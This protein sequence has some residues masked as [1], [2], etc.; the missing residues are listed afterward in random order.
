[1]TS[2]NKF[3]TLLFLIIS[4]SFLAA[5]DQIGIHQFEWEQYK[6]VE[7]APSKFDQEGKDIIPLNI[8]KAENLSAAVFGYLPDW[9]YNN[10]AHQYIRYDLLSHIACFDFFVS[11]NG[12][13]SN[14]GGW[15]WTDVINEAHTNGTKVIL[16]AVNFDPDD[17]RAIITNP[18]AKQ[19][20]FNNVKEKINTYSL[21]GVNIDFESLYN[22]DK[23]SLIV[24]F[25]TDLT[26]FIHSELPGK[27]VSFAGPAVNWGDH[28][29]I[30]GLAAS[31]DYIFIMGYAFAGSWSTITGANSPLTGGNIN[32]TNTLNDQYQQVTLNYPE[33]LILGIPYYGHHWV[34]AGS[35]AGSSI[36][37]FVSSTRFT[38][39]KPHAQ[40]Y[41]FNWSSQSQSTWYKWNDGQWHQIWYDDD[42][43]LG[44]KYDLA[45]SKNLKGVGMWALGYDK[46]RDELWNLLDWK[47]GSGVLPPPEKPFHF[48]VLTENDSTLLLKYNIPFRATGVRIFKSVN[49][50]TFTDSVDVSV[51]QISLSGLTT[52]SVYYFRIKSFNSSGESQLS[53]VL[54]GVPS[55]TQKHV[56]IV[57]G[58][59]RVSGTNNSFDLI[60]QYTLPLLENNHAFSSA[61]NEAVFREEIPC[62]NADVIIWILGDESTADETFNIYEQSVV[63]SFLNNGGKLFI[64]G[65]EIGYELDRPGVSSSNDISFYENYLKANYISDAPNNNS[66]FYYTAEPVSSEIFSNVGEFSFDDGTHGTF[67][68]DYPDAILAINGSENI[69]KF[70]NVTLSNGGAGIKY[71]GFF[72][73]G[74]SPGKLVYLSVPFET[75]YQMEKRVEIINQVFNF[76]DTP[77][78]IKNDAEIIPK[79][80][81][82]FQNY[83]NP[84]NP[85]TRFQFFTPKN[86]RAIIRI[87][88]VLGQVI[89]V[90]NFEEVKNGITEFYWNGQNERGDK[91]TSG[92]YIYRL[93]FFAV[94]GTTYNA[95]KKMILL[96]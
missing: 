3:K 63:K 39:D 78:S 61:S 1:L 75:I 72:P 5:Q 95:S 47:F 36:S 94:D 4:F 86:G 38:T 24:N 42:S 28:W 84:F 6:D 85:S 69:L 60:R 14:P 12:S 74:I 41:G 57:N 70:K 92:T 17:I 88:N 44:L 76:F 10:N 19:N 22:A 64:S 46:T 31:C 71:E 9:E 96:K 82:L 11:S 62:Q 49:G 50:I 7:F 56:L 59:D 8:E 35:S 55:N 87:F 26:A 77:V 37:Q 30:E 2:A 58:F 65:A 27:E 90:F 91:I 93:D 73:N 83:P 33:K 89:K 68:V 52:D 45:I 23:G 15:P 54:A 51:N 80:F 20:F 67:D 40:T 13:M 16:T 34:T 43:S 53:E 66:G 79:G 25:M 48:S 81:A 18:S 29:D 21:D 32:I